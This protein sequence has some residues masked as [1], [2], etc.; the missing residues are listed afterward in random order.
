MKWNSIHKAHIFWCRI[1][2]LLSNCATEKLW[3]SD[4]IFKRL[5]CVHVRLW[6]GTN[7]FVTCS[8]CVDLFLGWNVRWQFLEQRPIAYSCVLKYTQRLV[9]SD[10]NSY[11]LRGVC[12]RA[13]RQ[14]RDKKVRSKMDKNKLTI[15]DMCCCC[16]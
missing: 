3:K 2:L 8:E 16:V 4:A 7:T 5:M 13:H 14:R 11:V 10:R 1:W 15:C 6:R 12:A 9:D